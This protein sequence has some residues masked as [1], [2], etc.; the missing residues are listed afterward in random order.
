MSNV[1][2]SPEGNPEIWE[3]CPEDYTSEKEWNLQLQAKEKEAHDAAERER[4]KP[5]SLLV[6]KRKE[7]DEKYNWAMSQ[8]ISEY[9]EMEATLLFE[10][11]AADVAEYKRSG[12]VS[13]FLSTLA[14]T[15]MISVDDLVYKIEKRKEAYDKTAA[16]LLGIRHYYK[17]N[18][19]SLGDSITTEQLLDLDISY[20]IPKEDAQ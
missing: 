17:D 4:L 16:T 14:E 9:P 10:K 15:R 20:A 18:L 6:E 11:Q 8:L 2:Y 12:N 7:I 1:C 5:E 19:D 13:T 3:V